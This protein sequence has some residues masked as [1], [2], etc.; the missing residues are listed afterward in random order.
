MLRSS[1][2]TSALSTLCAMQLVLDPWGFDVILTTNL[3]G[4]I[5]SDEIAGLVGDLGMVPRREHWQRCSEL[6]G[7]AR[8]APDIAGRGIANPTALLL[9]AYLMLEHV[10]R[11]EVSG[12][13]RAAVA[14]PLRRRHSYPRLGWRRQHA[15]VPDAIVRRIGESRVGGRIGT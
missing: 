6:R 4:D 3:F 7:R 1:R 13:I 9:A 12:R 15:G 10:G 2:W 11:P 5:L 14:G 8:T